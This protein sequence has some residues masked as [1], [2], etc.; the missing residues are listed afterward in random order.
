MSGSLREK[1]N[2][3][4]RLRQAIAGARRGTSRGSR[5]SRSSAAAS[6]V[7]DFAGCGAGHGAAGPRRGHRR[8]RLPDLVEV[9]SS[10]WLLA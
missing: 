3:R 5:A 9:Y 6:G 2:S 7:D 1:W 8:R 10:G 4:A